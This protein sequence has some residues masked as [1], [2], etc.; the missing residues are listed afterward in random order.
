MAEAMT[1]PE[2]PVNAVV[3]L[4]PTATGKTRLGVHLARTF[5]GEV[6]SADSRQVYRGLDIGAGK[7]LAEYVV[8]GV[9]V[10][11]HLIDVVDPVDDEFSVYQ[12]QRCFHQVFEQLSGR[13]KLPVVV[14]G[15]GLYLEAVLRSYRMVEAPE[16]PGLRAELAALDDVALAARLAALR[17]LQ[18][19]T[20]DLLDRRRTIRA[21]EIATWEHRGSGGGSPLPSPE[22]RALLLGVRLPR[23]QLRQRIMRRLRE[24]LAGGLIEE[25]EGL[26]ARGVSRQ[27]LHFFGLE[28]RFVCQYLDREI[29]NRNDLTQKLHAAICAFA[30]RQETWF[31]RMERKAPIVWLEGTDLPRAE[32]LVRERLP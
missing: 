5:D 3:V 14:G 15:T 31:R 26:L 9:E 29:R 20:T 21:I 2:R 24:R 28:Y 17:P 8:E 10:P 27:K 18:H 32:Q 16:D 4:G 22:V 23:P 7:D 12:F 13:G 6:V 25:V 30:K 19:N 11:Y 1:I